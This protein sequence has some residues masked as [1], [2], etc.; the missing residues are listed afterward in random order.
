[1]LGRIFR[2][3]HFFFFQFEQQTTK[4]Q[5][6]L[7]LFFGRNKKR[8]T[9]SKKINYYLDVFYGEV[10]FDV[11]AEASTFVD[12]SSGAEF[13]RKETVFFISGSEVPTIWKSACRWPG[14]I[15]SRNSWKSILPSRLMSASCEKDQNYRD[16]HNNWDK[17]QRKMH[18]A[19]SK[20]I[21]L[22]F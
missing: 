8:K 22:G 15:I 16:Y 6:F 17:M 2:K 5:G 3:G 12:F 19:K 13:S 11:I 20:A 1:M 18:Y 10:V 21:R 7:W 14:N 9:V 4:I